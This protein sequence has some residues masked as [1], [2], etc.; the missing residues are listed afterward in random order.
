MNIQRI[1]ADTLFQQIGT[2][3][4]KELKTLGNRPGLPVIKIVYI[5]GKVTGL[6]YQTV[7]KK[8]ALR[9]QQLILDGYVVINP[10]DLISEHEDWHVAMKISLALLSFA[11]CINM[12][13]DWEDSEGA[14]LELQVAR[15]LR[16]SELNTPTY[17]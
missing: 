17:D 4:K 14:R 16:I 3:F 6:D 7:R 9:E 10:T 5:S 15:K 1:M 8:F 13:P 2:F 12:L 11:D